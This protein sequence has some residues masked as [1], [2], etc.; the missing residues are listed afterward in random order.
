VERSSTLGKICREIDDVFIEPH[1]MELNHD[2]NGFVHHV[3]KTG[4]VLYQKV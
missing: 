3:Q 2:P 4:N 1:L